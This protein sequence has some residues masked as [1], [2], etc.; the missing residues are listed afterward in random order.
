MPGCNYSCI[1]MYLGI[2]KGYEE[3]SVASSPSTTREHDLGYVESRKVHNA[4]K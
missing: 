4:T 3:Q 1:S 2:H